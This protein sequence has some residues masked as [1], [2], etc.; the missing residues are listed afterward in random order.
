MTAQ[1]PTAEE[2]LTQALAALIEADS[3]TGSISATALC[4]RAGVSRN[5]LYRY[6]PA[7]LKELRKSR[8][9]RSR[10]ATSLR[11]RTVNQR[12]KILSLQAINAQLAALVDHYYLAYQEAS[13]LLTRRESELARLRRALASKPALLRS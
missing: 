4:Q 13:A 9:Q 10:A 6:H 8:S 7:I 1:T 2:R 3:R 11:Q 5:S 12:Q